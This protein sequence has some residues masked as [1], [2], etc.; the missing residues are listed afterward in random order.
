V[1]TFTDVIERAEMGLMGM[2]IHPNFST[3]RWMYFAYGYQN[4][5]VKVVR[6]REQNNA[7]TD[8]TTIIDNLPA[9]AFHAGRSGYRAGPRQLGR[10][11]AA[12]ER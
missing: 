12:P 5:A 3:N 7:L 2:A 10:Q 11:D 6:L 4:D 1:H 9:A 8:A